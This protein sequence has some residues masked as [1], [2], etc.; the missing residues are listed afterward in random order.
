MSKNKKIALN[1]L[2]LV[3]AVLVKILIVAL[4]LYLVYIFV[5]DVLF[6]L[7]PFVWENIH[8]VSILAI[9]FILMCEKE[10]SNRSLISSLIYSFRKVKQK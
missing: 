9:I 7:A 4:F 5:T 3:A 6:E 1:V 2:E 8:L 10:G